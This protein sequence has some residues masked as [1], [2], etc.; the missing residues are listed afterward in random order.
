[1]KTRYLNEGRKK[2][3]EKTVD[4]LRPFSKV[5]YHCLADFLNVKIIKTD[6]L[7]E[8][9]LVKQGKR[10]YLL[11]TESV[12][13]LTRKYSGVLELGHVALEHLN[14]EETDIELT[15]FIKS[16]MDEEAYYFCTEPWIED[17]A[18]RIARENK[19]TN[20]IDNYGGR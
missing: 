17:E 6:K 20:F 14:H 5:D 13:P 1:M 4:H 10:Y 11:E 7:G 2:R 3:I 12:F 15:P 18:D 9:V 19:R 16:V 8:N